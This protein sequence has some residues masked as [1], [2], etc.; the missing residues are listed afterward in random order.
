[1]SDLH[2]TGAALLLALAVL[3]PGAARP[4]PGPEVSWSDFARELSLPADDPDS[5]A[6]G[7]NSPAGPPTGRHEVPNIPRGEL[8]TP[9][10]SVRTTRLRAAAVCGH[11]GRE[12]GDLEWD[13]AA[14]AKSPILRPPGA[15]PPRL[16]PPGARLRCPHCSGPV[17]TDG[18]EPVVVRPPVALSPARRG[19]PRNAPRRAS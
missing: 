18:P 11:C 19:R 7:S 8:F 10:D 14:P 13:P 9:A 15:A 2:W 6:A 4:R 12:V 17:F 5:D 3:G 16:V 1:M